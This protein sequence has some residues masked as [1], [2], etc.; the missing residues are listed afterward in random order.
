VYVVRDWRSVKCQ[1]Y[2][3]VVRDLEIYSALQ[4]EIGQMV[5][6]MVQL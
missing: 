4:S 3:Y 5:D 6:N 1:V 2:Q